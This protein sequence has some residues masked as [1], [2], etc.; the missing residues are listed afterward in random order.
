MHLKIVLP[1]IL[2]HLLISVIIYFL[3]IQSMIFSVCCYLITHL[4]LPLFTLI[5]TQIEFHIAIE[6]IL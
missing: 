2:L 6:I 3:L 1:D 5:V 4:C